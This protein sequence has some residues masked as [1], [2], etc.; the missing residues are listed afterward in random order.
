[1]KHH[2]ASVLSDLLDSSET[3]LIEHGQDACLVRAPEIRGIA[4][5]GVTW[6]EDHHWTVIVLAVDMGLDNAETVADGGDIPKIPER[7][8]RVIEHPE[9]E[10]DIEG[11]DSLRRDFFDGDD[12][13]LNAASECPMSDLKSPSIAHSTRDT[14][15]VPVGR[16]D[17]GGTPSFSFERKEPV[18]GTDVE[19]SA[20]GEGFRESKVCK[21]RWRIVDSWRNDSVSE[22]DT[23]E[24]LAAGGQFPQES[25]VNYRG[26]GE[27]RTV[28]VSSIP[29]VLAAH[30]TV[31]A[32]LIGGGGGGLGLASFTG[33]RMAA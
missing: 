31:P 29:G 10:Y 21:L 19:H 4:G 9:E 11:S 18:I 1:M 12:L 32:M 28:H 17:S 16:D 23:M 8:G 5:Q 26:Q 27:F 2:P 14:P 6:V 22:V 13:P 30:C 20:T 15:A 3:D 7:V 33:D 24:P 25:G